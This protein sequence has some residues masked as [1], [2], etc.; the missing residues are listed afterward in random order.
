MKNKRQ[1][2][3]RQKYRIDLG[4]QIFPIINLVLLI[5]T[6]SDKLIKFTHVPKTWMLVLALIPLSLLAVWLFGYI[7]DRLK[8]RQAYIQEEFG[9][10]GGK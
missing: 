10:N 6:A 4:Y 9:R 7:L 2:L 1:W 3:V 8:Y 5:I